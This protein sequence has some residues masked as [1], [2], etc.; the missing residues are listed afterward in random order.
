LSFPRKRESML[1]KE[2]W[3]HAFA[4]KTR[5]QRFTSN[6]D[7]QI[8]MARIAARRMDIGFPIS[9]NLVITGR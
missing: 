2:K 9:A 5:V 4:G 8:R 6:H 7:A 1:F 3:F